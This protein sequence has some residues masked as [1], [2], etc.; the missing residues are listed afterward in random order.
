M[1]TNGPVGQSALALCDHE[2]W[3]PRATGVS[4]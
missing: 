1:E 3:K 4:L 2:R